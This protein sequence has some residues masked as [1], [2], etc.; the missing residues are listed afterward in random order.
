MNVMGVRVKH[1][2]WGDIVLLSLRNL[3]SQLIF[4]ISH[5]IGQVA[6]QKEVVTHDRPPG[7]RPAKFV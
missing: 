1:G 5:F 6:L 4:V 7:L 3:F 2:T